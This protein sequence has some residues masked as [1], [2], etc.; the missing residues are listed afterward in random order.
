MDENKKRVAL[1]RCEFSDD[2]IKTHSEFDCKGADV[3]AFVGMTLKL[4]SGM[5][6]MDPLNAA[7]KCIV[8]CNL[9]VEAKDEESENGEES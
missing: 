5:M 1:V 8:F 2:G 6:N 9:A 4:V 7:K 3:M